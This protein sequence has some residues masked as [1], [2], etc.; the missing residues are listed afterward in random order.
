[1]EEIITKK[2]TK[3]GE[4]KSLE[5]YY[6]KV[7]GKDGHSNICKICIS[8]ISKDRYA[9]DS[10]NIRKKTRDYAIKNKEKTKKHNKIIG[11]KINPN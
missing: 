5:E 3:C 10:I 11:L 6:K 9:R 1:M 2:C 8:K 7:T 4:I